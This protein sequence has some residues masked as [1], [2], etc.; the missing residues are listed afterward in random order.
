VGFVWFL[1]GILGGDGLISGGEALCGLRGLW[2]LGEGED[3]ICGLWRV[4]GLAM[5]GVAELEGFW[6]GV[7]ADDGGWSSFWE[8][9]GFGSLHGGEDVVLGSD[10]TAGSICGGAV[11]LGSGCAGVICGGIVG[12]G[13]GC[14]DGLIFGGVSFVGC[15][16]ERF[17]KSDGESVITCEGLVWDG[18]FAQKFWIWMESLLAW[19][20][21]ELAELLWSSFRWPWLLA[22]RVPNISSICFVRWCTS[23]QNSSDNMVGLI[24]PES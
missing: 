21:E 13:S 18:S 19:C 7:C 2:V 3:N 6:G 16:S 10:C 9:M 1:G 20:L 4:W 24:G 22:I 8:E 14:T 12:L 15:F 5:V 23:A 11:G 17:S